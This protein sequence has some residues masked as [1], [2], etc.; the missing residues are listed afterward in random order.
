MDQYIEFARRHGLKWETHGKY[1]E[2]LWIW[3]RRDRSKARIHG[4]SLTFYFPQGTAKHTGNLLP[5]LERWVC[6]PSGMSPN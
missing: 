3:S 2:V 6:Q 4:T 5:V 1:N